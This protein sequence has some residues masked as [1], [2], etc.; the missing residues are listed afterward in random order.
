[1]ASLGEISLSADVE[2]EFIGI[3]DLNTV[4]RPTNKSSAK[5]VFSK[6][7]KNFCTWRHSKAPDEAPPFLPTLLLTVLA[8]DRMHRSTRFSQSNY[9]GRLC[10][11]LGIDDFLSNEVGASYRK[12]IAPL[13][14]MYCQW[15]QANP[16]IGIPTAYEDSSRGSIDYVGVPIG[17]ALLRSHEQ[18]HIEREF[19]SL[20]IEGN[21]REEVEYEDFISSLKLWIDGNTA[22]DRIKIAYRKAPAEIETAIWSIFNR[23]APTEQEIRTAHRSP[24]LQLGCYVRP[25]FG[26]PKAN[27]YL[28]STDDNIIE[29]KLKLVLTVETS[30]CEI[31][32]EADSYLGFGTRILGCSL[33]DLLHKPVSL[34]AEPENANSDIGFKTERNPR[35]VIPF[36]RLLPNAWVETKW[37]K[38]GKTYNLLVA[39]S[40]L[41]RFINVLESTGRGGGCKEL[42]GVPNEWQLITDFTLLKSDDNSSLLPVRP[43]SQRALMH[44][45]GVRL[46]GAGQQL[47]FPTLESPSILISRDKNDKKYELH[48]TSATGS[49][50][51]VEV[52]EEIYQL[53]GRPEGT[54]TIE[55]F[56][57]GA[58][59]SAG[60]LRLTL[61]D[62]SNPRITPGLDY[63]KVSIRLG[64]QFGSGV[65]SSSDVQAKDCLIQGATTLHG[66]L[67]VNTRGATSANSTLNFQDTDAESES[68]Y[69]R[70]MF[71]QLSNRRFEWSPCVIDPTAKHLHT[72]GEI[73]PPG[74]VPKWIMTTCLKCG[75]VFPV[76]S[77]GKPK[78]FVQQSIAQASVTF[79]GSNEPTNIGRPQIET[80]NY[81]PIDFDKLK[82]ENRLW[83]LGAGDQH[84]A[85]LFSDLH[86]D[87][88]TSEVMW[89]LAAAGHIDSAKMEHDLV[90]EKWV[91]TPTV[92]VPY[93][94][95]QMRMV[96]HRSDEV[97]EKISRKFCAG[98]YPYLENSDASLPYASEL[99]FSSSP[100]VT[101][102]SLTEFLET[103]HDLSRVQVD[104][105]TSREFLYCLPSLT[106]LKSQLA[107]VD[108]IDT[109][110]KTRVFELLTRKW[111]E[112]ND[113]VLVGQSV[114]EST[115]GNQYFYLYSGNP[116]G[117]KAIRCGYR[118]AK[119]F[120]AH[121][122]KQILFSYNSQVQELSCPLGAELPL[123]YTR[124]VIFASGTVP[125]KRGSRI[126][127]QGVGAE[128]AELLLS[129]FSK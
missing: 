49:T 23:W 69:I 103:D 54:W 7:Q 66:R 70:P 53:N 89:H 80:T 21:T 127:Y 52:V 106:E 5:K 76:S 47:E 116:R 104:Q 64:Q 22:T 42:P 128:L 33:D 90:D 30:K 111:V 97:I 107:S 40:V 6:L 67:H 20:F 108:Y 3:F 129:L 79:T 34:I 84:S 1:M 123:L 110:S 71:A 87:Q 93:D 83:C 14:T 16:H 58:K 68:E 18:K 114:K 17:Q 86:H 115:F 9:Y 48:L 10:E 46:P 27:F 41:K 72:V 4:E 25:E 50:E 39:K 120:T 118:L 73:P 63:K 36:E 81:E 12:Q 13:W 77:R 32:T 44:M 121:H 78:K 65:W 85:A 92:I 62:S 2:S 24:L 38:I 11:M 98:N 95:G 31:T 88:I 119:H 15:L 35:V 91:V 57:S 82:V 19:F 26:Q 8:A 55:L 56:A 102:H 60:A 28:R 101:A 74:R 51:T 109:P 37:M 45:G 117:Y 124:G 100:D 43:G 125:I 105:I 75:A 59:K 96:G 126:I 122:H 113:G 112:P 61:R 99:N 29:R 94:N